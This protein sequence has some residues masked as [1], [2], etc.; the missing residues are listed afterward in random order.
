MKTKLVQVDQQINTTKELFEAL[1]SGKVVKVDRWDLE[2]SP[3]GNLNVDLVCSLDVLVAQIHGVYERVESPWYE[4]ME[5][6][7]TVLI[8]KNEKPSHVV[9]LTRDDEGYFWKFESSH[10]ADIKSLIYY[11]PLTPEEVA[12][13]AFDNIC[14]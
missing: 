4:Y 8:K 12:K 1:L 6:G 10:K 5:V 13:F 14:N 7:Q 9:S 3:S 2:L 11:T